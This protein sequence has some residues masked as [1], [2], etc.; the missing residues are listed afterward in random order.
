LHLA[1]IGEVVIGEV[2]ELQLSEA[3][4]ETE[5]GGGRGAVR[6]GG[7]HGIEGGHLVGADV[8]LLQTWKTTRGG[9]S[10]YLGIVSHTVL[11]RSQQTGS[12]AAS[13]ASR[14]AATRT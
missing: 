11:A 7:I 14:H 4:N 6:G 9:H 12:I 8:E 13:M 3:P 10:V 2:E 5:V 1:P